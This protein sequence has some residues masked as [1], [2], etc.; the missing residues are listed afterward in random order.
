MEAVVKVVEEEELRALGTQQHRKQS[1]HEKG[2]LAG[3]MCRDVRCP[4]HVENE[5]ISHNLTVDVPCQAIF[6]DSYV[7]C[8]GVGYG[9]AIEPNPVYGRDHRAQ[10]L[11]EFLKLVRLI[12]GHVSQG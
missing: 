9:D 1:Q 7:L 6:P 5:R 12:Q 11:L 8:L 4:A 2:S 3:K 10:R